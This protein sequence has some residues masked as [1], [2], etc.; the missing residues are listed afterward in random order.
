MYRAGRILIVPFFNLSMSVAVSPS[1][2]IAPRALM[3]DETLDD[4]K[5]SLELAMQLQAEEEAW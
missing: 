1:S 2:P 3:L 4:E 5:Q